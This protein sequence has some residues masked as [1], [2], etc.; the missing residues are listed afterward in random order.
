MEPSLLIKGKH[1][2]HLGH[3]SFRHKW[4][5]RFPFKDN[6]SSFRLKK[7]SDKALHRLVSLVIVFNLVHT[8]TYDILPLTSVS[9]FIE[10]LV[11]WAQRLILCGI[12]L[13]IATVRLINNKTH[14][15]IFWQVIDRRIRKL[16]KEELLSFDFFCW[17]LWVNGKWQ[18][19]WQILWNIK[20]IFYAWKEMDF[21]PPN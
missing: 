14:K 21:L 12:C 18:W 6:R 9:I 11:T 20:D 5:A 19:K 8:I 7:T 17:W 10:Q 4:R 1:K 3:W 13:L 15:L 2:S 16:D